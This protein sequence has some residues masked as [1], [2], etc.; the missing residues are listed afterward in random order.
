LRLN[1]EYIETSQGVKIPIIEAK[2]LLKLI[3][4]KNIIG[5]RVDNRFIVKSFDNILKVGCH[6][7]DI[8]EINYIKNLI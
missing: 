8:K 2:R 3:D 7:I 5:E 6:N 1:S 4:T